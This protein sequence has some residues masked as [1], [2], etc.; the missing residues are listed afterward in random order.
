MRSLVE[1]IAGRAVIL[2]GS[3]GTSLTLPANF[4]GNVED[5]YLVDVD[6]TLVRVLSPVQPTPRVYNDRQYR[7][8]YS[9]ELTLCNTDHRH[10]IALQMDSDLTITVPLGITPGTSIRLLTLT[11]SPVKLQINGA[12]QLIG[13]NVGNPVKRTITLTRYQTVLLTWTDID[14]LLISYVD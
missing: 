3:D 14:Q 12:I 11:T 10:T 1:N 6:T 9:S 4:L 5:K 13:S 7:I 2:A 8:E